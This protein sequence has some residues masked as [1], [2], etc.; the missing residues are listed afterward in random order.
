MPATVQMPCPVAACDAR[1][2]VTVDLVLGGPDV[3]P[4][5]Q[6]PG[7]PGIT[8]PV[9]AQI[10]ETSYD[11]VNEHMQTAHPELGSATV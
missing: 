7:S 4:R 2:P 3:L 6:V 11:D 10:N 9:Q 8:I 1:I 5:R